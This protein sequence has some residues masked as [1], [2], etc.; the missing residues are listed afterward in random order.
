MKGLVIFSPE[1][2][3]LAACC[4]TNKIPSSWIGVSYP[5]LKPLQ[6]YVGDFL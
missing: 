5:S 6:S 1:L 4:L 3:E 2:E